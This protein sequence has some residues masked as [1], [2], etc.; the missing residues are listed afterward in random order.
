[1]DVLEELAKIIKSLNA[2]DKYKDS[3]TDKLSEQ[4]KKLSDLYHYIE[5]NKLSTSQCYRMIKEIK[6]QRNIRRK[7]KCDMTLFST[8][9]NHI[10][11]ML[12]TDNRNMLLA[13]LHKANN[14]IHTE[15]K[16]RIY[17]EEEIK[18]LLGVK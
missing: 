13:E 9:D 12:K 16:N 6:T 8:Y 7:I 10:N 14:R 5:D 3:L 2:I 17:T 4:D 18:E 1:M 11:K 15:Y